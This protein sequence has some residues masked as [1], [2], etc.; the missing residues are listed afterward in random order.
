MKEYYL[1][2]YSTSEI[3]SDIANRV[4]NYQT[5]NFGNPSS[6]HSKGRKIF[7]DISD[8]RCY[9][10]KKL[11]YNKNNRCI[12]FSSAS[13]AISTIVR[14]V[15]SKNKNKTVICIGTE[16][17]ASI[18]SSKYWAREY[19]CKAIF[20]NPDLN[21]KIDCKS[22]NNII[23]ENSVVLIIG[24][25]CNNETG[26]ILNVKDIANIALSNDIFFMV[27]AVASFG[28]IED[29]KLI[30]GIS[31]LI[32]SSHKLGGPIG[33]AISIFNKMPKFNGLIFGGS[34]EFGLVSGTENY[35]SIYGMRLIVE[36]TLLNIKDNINKKNHIRDIF[37][38]YILNNIP[39]AR[40]HA[41]NNRSSGV[42]NI[43]F[44]GVDGE[45]LII[46]LDQ[47]KV[48]ASQGSACNAGAF[49]ISHVLLSMGIS[50]EEA[51]SS[52]RFSFT[53]SLSDQEIKDAAKIVV[54]CFN[55]LKY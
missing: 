20:I 3:N 41:L 11:G 50:K 18:E 7:Q 17:K 42:S 13:E 22:L 10:E 30:P 24:S 12:F 44:P 29:V 9:I 1:D 19:N 4:Y 34:Q 43:Y 23:E 48:Y 40:I 5:M 6:Q 39:G 8:T 51:I 54:K 14:G 27:D 31:S 21:G 36:D 46:S 25:W 55:D 52:I 26:S 2:S 28:K 38:E 15:L 49:E 35:P 37:E 33:I 45:S 47:N 32:I 53:S 16:H